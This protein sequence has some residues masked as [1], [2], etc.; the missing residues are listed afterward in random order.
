MNSNSLDTKTIFGAQSGTLL[1]GVKTN[2]QGNPLEGNYQL[3][4]WSELKNSENPYSVT[5]KEDMKAKK[6]AQ[7]TLAKT[8]AQ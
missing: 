1:K 7:S 4:G 8:G 2:R 6:T 3:P 5:K